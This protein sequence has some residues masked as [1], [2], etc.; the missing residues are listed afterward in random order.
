MGSRGRWGLSPEYYCVRLPWVDDFVELAGVE[1]CVVVVSDGDGNDVCSRWLQTCAHKVL[2]E[3]H[4]SIEIEVESTA[5][6]AAARGPA[7]A[8]SPTGG[9]GVR[10]V[11][12]VVCG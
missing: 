9:G 10:I 11:V 4:S 12:T 5:A 6:G 2:R 8:A 1:R 3:G 7:S